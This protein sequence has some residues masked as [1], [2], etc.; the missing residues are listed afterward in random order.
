MFQVEI[1]QLSSKLFRQLHSGADYILLNEILFSDLIGDSTKN[2]FRAEIEWWIYK[3]REYKYSVLDLQDSNSTLNQLFNSLDEVFRERARFSAQDLRSLLKQYVSVRLNFLCRPRETL[4]QF[5]F[6]DKSSCSIEEILLRIDY[7]SEY[8]YLYDGIR[9]WFFQLEHERK[10]KVFLTKEQF[11]TLVASID[12]SV[13]LADDFTPEAFVELLSPLFAFFDVASSYIP[14]RSV[15]IETLILFLDDKEIVPI[16]KLLSELHHSQNI[17]YV[18]KTKLLSLIKNFTEVAN[19]STSDVE[20]VIN[21]QRLFD[22]YSIRDNSNF[23]GKTA[24]QSDLSSRITPTFVVDKIEAIH[25]SNNTELEKDS[26]DSILENVSSNIDFIYNDELFSNGDL[27]SGLSSLSADPLRFDDIEFPSTKDDSISI[28]EE[29]NPF[30]TFDTFFNSDPDMQT[31]EEVLFIEEPSTSIEPT[32]L[33]IPESL[34]IIQEFDENEE[35]IFT[36]FAESSLALNAVPSLEDS[37][38][39]VP[40]EK[41]E[42]SSS[43]IEEIDTL[44]NLTNDLGSDF[45]DFS[46]DMNQNV[47]YENEDSFGFES[48]DTNNDFE[49]IEESNNQSRLYFSE[50]LHNE[51]SEVVFLSNSDEIEELSQKLFST[52]TYDEALTIVIQTIIDND[53]SPEDTILQ[54]I[55]SFLKVKYQG[56]M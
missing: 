15:P 29:F 28:E 49:A 26:F 30:E 31:A 23:L 51:I 45:N 24:I 35:D 14:P 37:E 32:S 10:D 3:E 12:D 44:K 48:I 18:S 22:S 33:E 5:V 2:F 41:A 20:E 52:T 42:D 7:F 19:S 1:D 39:D 40:A 4:K 25:I 55:E 46:V 16:A 11:Q 53:I 43:L 21:Q 8:P 50:E 38:I 27:T 6:R 34:D 36:K 9:S 56:G 54:K 17:R 13:L 47:S